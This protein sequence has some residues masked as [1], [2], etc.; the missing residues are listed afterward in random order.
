MFTK[1]HRITIFKYASKNLYDI[2]SH[3]IV[4][5]FPKFNGVWQK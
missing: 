3:N 5:V 4:K 2:D 1:R